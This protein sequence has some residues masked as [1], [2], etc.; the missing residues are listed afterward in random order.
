MMV[1]HYITRRYQPTGEIVVKQLVAHPRGQGTS[2][3]MNL[4]LQYIHMTSRLV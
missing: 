1:N 4:I 2:I 3:G